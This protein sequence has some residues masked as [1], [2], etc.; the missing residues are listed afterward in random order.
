MRQSHEIEIGAGATSSSNEHCDEARMEGPRPRL[1]LSP[2][3]KS[4]DRRWPMR[5]RRRDN[6]FRA[7]AGPLQL[8]SRRSSRYCMYLVVWK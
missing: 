3:L 2:S 8:G 7:Y 4:W 5:Q 1:E 6:G